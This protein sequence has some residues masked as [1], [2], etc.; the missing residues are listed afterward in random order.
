MIRQIYVG[1]LCCIWIT[2]LG[3]CQ[4]QTTDRGLVP[5]NQLSHDDG[6]VLSGAKAG[7]PVTAISPASEPGQAKPPNVVFILADDLGWRDL[8]CEG[9]TFYETPN[10]DRICREGMRFRNGYAA[11]QVCSP[12]RAAIMT[13]KSP[14][15][16]KITDYIGAPSGDQWKRNTKL[17]PA[18]YQRQLPAEEETLAE[19]F[20]AAG[21][22]TFFAGK[23]HLGNKGSHP[24]DHGFDV[25]VGGFR[26]GTPPGGF[27]VP[28]KNPKMDDGPTGECLP[29]RLGEETANFIRQNK[30]RP[31]FAMLAFYSVHAPLQTSQPLWEKYREKYWEKA[32]LQPP[33]EQRFIIDR[34]MPVRQVQDHPVYAGMVESMDLGVG[35]VLTALEETALTDDTIVIF[36]SDNGG[37][38]SGDGFATSNLPLRGGKGRQWEGGIREPY[39]FRWPSRIAAGSSS[40]VPVIGMDFYPTLMELCQLPPRPTQTCDGVSL[41]PIFEGGVIPERTLFWHYPHYGNQ[42]GEPSSISRLGDWKL[43]RYLEDQ[44]V[45]LYNIKT[46]PGEA[47]DVAANNAARVAQM[48]TALDQWLSEVQAE[49]PTRNLKF[50]PEAY[51]KWQVKMREERLPIMEQTHA[52]FL[53]SGFQP[54]KGW[55]DQPAPAQK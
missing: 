54:R 26:A 10:I 34:T 14:A 45:E 29:V 6:R 53:K 40:E 43:I 51:K 30:S 52:R 39:Y 49:Q 41:A 5:I 35:K 1:L 15:R 50:D 7:Q 19:A 9:S 32:Q 8:S 23:W 44:R 25:N 13:G 42:G 37:V 55:W 28:Y 48:T 47:K 3:F 12:S 27:F 38:S 21:Y 36:T 4:A 22:Q 18:F 11:C 33:I 46:D 24:E 16:I 17:L 2:G 20:Q 31:F